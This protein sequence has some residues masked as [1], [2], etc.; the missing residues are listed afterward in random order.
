MTDERIMGLEI[1]EGETRV[2]EVILPQRVGGEF[3]TL[4]TQQQFAGKRVIVFGLPGA[5]T[6]TCS[7]QQLPGFDENFEKFQEKGI[8]EIYCVSV[9]DTFVMNSWFESLGI[10]NVYP[11]PD[12]N[13]EFTHL[14]GAE[15]SKSNLGFGYRS[16]RY[17][18]VVNDGVIEKAFIEDGYQ[19]NAESDP[20][21][22]SSPENLL[23]NL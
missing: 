6:P 13:G 15:C 17:A 10:K 12:G 1:I 4:D 11:L 8:D 18:I 21:E 22:F 2:P 3:V 20:Y 16:W 7:T 23:E 19:D 14:I 5:F 9:N